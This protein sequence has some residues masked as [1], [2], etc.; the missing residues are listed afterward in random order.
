VTFD[1]TGNLYGTTTYAIPNG[2]TVYELSPTGIYTVTVSRMA[3]LE[4]FRLPASYAI[5]PATYMAQLLRVAMSVAIIGAGSFT[6]SIH[7]VQN[8]SAQ[9]YRLNRSSE[10]L[11]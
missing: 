8:C 7:L 9:L 10:A 11:N 5:P 2:G 1:P 6:K 3:R 4:F